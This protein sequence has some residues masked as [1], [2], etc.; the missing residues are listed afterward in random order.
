MQKKYTSSGRA[1]RLTYRRTT[2]SSI[3]Q[4]H[5]DTPQ[6]PPSPNPAHHPYFKSGEVLAREPHDHRSFAHRRTD[7]VNRTRAAIACANMPG[8]L[9][10]TGAN[11]A[12]SSKCADRFRPPSAPAVSGLRKLPPRDPR[13]PPV[14]SPSSAAAECSQSAVNQRILLVGKCN[15]LLS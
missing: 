8:P 3:F 5:L 4:K 7:S 12:S 10:W 15:Y 14:R 1:S 9:L 13:L 2:R 11:H 6:S